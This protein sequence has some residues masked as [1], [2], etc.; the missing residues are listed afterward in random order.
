MSDSSSSN[1][2]SR[3]EKMVSFLI[4]SVAILAAIITSLQ[5]YTSGKASE[6]KRISSQFAIQAMQVKASGETRVSHDRQ[7][8]YQ[9]WYELD[10]QAL[11]AG[12]A[13]DAAAAARYRAVRDKIA[14]LAPI[15]SA[16]YYDPNTSSYPDVARYESD[17]YL[18]ESTRLSEK[19]TAYN[20][21]GDAW[22]GRAKAFIVH[23]TL[24]AVTLSLYGLSTTLRGFMRSV[25]VGLGTLIAGV[26]VLW[27]IGVMLLP[28]PTIPEQA[29][30]A[31][32][33]GVGKAWYGDSQGAI[34]DFDKALNLKPDYANAFYER[35][36]AYYNQGD[37][38]AAIS[39]YEAAQSAGR[40]DTNVGW[41]L[42]W[43]YYMVGRFED[44]ILQDQRVLAQDPS[45]IGVRFNL[46]IALMARGNFAEAEQEYYRGVNQA[47]DEVTRAHEQGLQPPSS[48]WY[49]MD[50]SA[51]DI[52]SLLLTLDGT[53]KSWTQA[54]S[55]GS[56]VID[57]G[58]L[59]TE[60][61]NM[62]QLL[63]DTTTALEFSG[64]APDPN[65]IFTASSFQFA[66][67]EYDK[68]GN[69]V[70]YN[71]A[72]TFPSGTDEMVI[73]F[74]YNNATPGQSEVWKVYLN[75]SEDPTLRVI[76]TWGLE[77][78]GSASKAISYAYSNLFTFA[79]G[80]YT[81]ELYIDNHLVQRGT[82]IVE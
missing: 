22:D 20:A 36:N 79:S 65:V 30:E 43:S 26:V 59:R 66:Q 61:H 13:G 49:Y 17:V 37:L 45:L 2:Q 56:I 76:G 64:T 47:V 7:G 75:G 27:A 55:L 21:L 12:I 67:E 80:E 73:L 16:P 50:A 82:F 72:T 81:V 34:A 74:D 48:F 10:L 70:R 24:L 35:G 38:A 31:Y 11:A 46:A 28:V 39:N 4:A 63:K 3:S 23:L 40:S 60:A 69:F 77:Q 19:F 68:D 54:P 1:E 44:A 29:I 42:G 78:T 5:T 52:E 14:K 33:Q 51:Q 9:T 6:A 18:V 71:I 32:A 53:P 58:Q 57:Q 15:F 62:F 41:N 8:A 25:F